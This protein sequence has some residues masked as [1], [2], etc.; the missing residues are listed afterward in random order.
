M[1][2]VLLSESGSP[3]GEAV[4]ESIPEDGRSRTPTP[5]GIDVQKGGSMRRSGWVLAGALL[6]VCLVATVAAAYNIGV[7]V[8]GVVAGSPLYEDMV[9]GVEKVA[10]ENSDVTYKVLEAGF[11]Q[12]TWEEQM[13]NLVAT[14]EYD[15]IVSSNP[16]MPEVS[17]QAAEA[18]PDQKFLFVDAVIE[19]NPQM[20]SVLYNQMEQAGVM[21]YLAGLITE[22]DMAGATPE[23]KVGFLIGQEYSSQEHMIL[24]GYVQGAKLANPAIEVDFRVLGNWW[25]ANK[26]GELAN[27]MID[28]GVDVIMTACGGANTGVIAACEERG[29]YVLYLDKD[30]YDLSPGTIIGCSALAQADAVYENVKAAIAG[31]LVWGE[32]AILGIS[33]GYVDFVDTNPLYAAG[34]STEV[35]NEMKVF[36]LDLRSSFDTWLKSQMIVP[37]FW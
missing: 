18:F 31:E 19:G 32:Y 5:P 20:Y 22:S 11:D 24:P 23:L 26:A 21:G 4:D 3:K 6:A 1:A 8:P 30:N 9:A 10:A 36:L 2:A 29:K 7:Y 14:G 12:S 13:M 27:S 34:V 16:S 28:A 25:D 33:D 17:R 15:L 37:E 35:F